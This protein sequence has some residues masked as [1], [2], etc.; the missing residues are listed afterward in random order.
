MDGTMTRGE[1][2]AVHRG[3]DYRLD[4]VD[5]RLDSHSAQL[6]HSATIE[7]QQKEIIKQQDTLL[8]DLNERVKAIEQRGSKRGET[9]LVS[10]MSTVFGGFLM[11]LFTRIVK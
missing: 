9:V 2:A 4:K 8:Q 7:A 1:C 5:D 10:G 6:E 11:W 3:L